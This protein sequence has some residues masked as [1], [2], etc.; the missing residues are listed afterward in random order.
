MT[1]N[2]NSSASNDLLLVKITPKSHHERDYAKYSKDIAEFNSICESLGIGFNLEKDE[3]KEGGYYST[4]TPSIIVD[5]AQLIGLMRANYHVTIDSTYEI[6][7]TDAYLKNVAEAA[8]RILAK[9][10]NVDAG[11]FP[12]KTYNEKCDV[13]VPGIGLLAIN[14]TMLLEDACTDQLNTALAN[15]WR[16][17]A[18]CPQPDQRRPDY[19][20]GKYDPEWTPCD[21]VGA[22]RK[23]SAL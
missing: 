12:E 7:T 14:R 1:Q 3:E 2:T 11:L 9:L 16:I 5:A 8:E 18:A 4:T 20:L 15:G 10:A 13:H 19:I 23:A 22:E 21:G 17:I 6:K